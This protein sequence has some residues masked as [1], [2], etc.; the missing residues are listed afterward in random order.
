MPTP[1][2]PANFVAPSAEWLRENLPPTIHDPPA[3]R[4]NRVS[5]TTENI[6]EA[7]RAE[8]RRQQ[9]G[10]DALKDIGSVRII[11]RLRPAPS[12]ILQTET[13]DT[14]ARRPR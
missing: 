14:P 3:T 12:V 11:V 2:G 13:T 7:V 5:T 9:T 6:F 1:P 4:P 10:L 8:L